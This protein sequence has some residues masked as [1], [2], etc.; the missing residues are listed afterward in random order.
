LLPVYSEKN[1][2]LQVRNFG[3]EDCKPGHEYGPVVREFF[4]FHYIFSGC[5]VFQAYNQTHFL[6]EGQGFLI[7]PKDLT[8]YKA[9]NSKPWAYGWFGVSGLQAEN[10]FSESGLTRENPIWRGGK[11]PF[12]ETVLMDMSNVNTVKPFTYPLLTGYAYILL[13]RLIERTNHPTASEKRVSRQETYLRAAINYIE[14]NYYNKLTI[15]EV[16]RYVGLDRSYLGSLFI[17]Y[18]HIS[19]QDFLINLRMDKACSLLENENLRV[20]DVARSVGYPDQLHFSRIFKTRKGVTPT[21]F[22]LQRRLS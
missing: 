14:Q 1:L 19:M 16:S 21:E 10:Y 4:L 3:Y 9:D 6:Q 2:D 20:G 5:G 17:K 18:L 7:H 22:K 13:A 8:F 11:D 15:D 12:L